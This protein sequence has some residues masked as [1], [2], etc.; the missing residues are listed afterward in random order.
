MPERLECEV[1][2]KAHYINTL[3]FTFIC[4][5]DVSSLLELRFHYSLYV[6][7]TMK[8]MYI[9]LVD[10]LLHVSSTLEFH[11]WNNNTNNNNNGFV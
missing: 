9:L 3:T 1:L 2:H 6:K 4:V 8:L 7:R 5:P 11:F 10:L